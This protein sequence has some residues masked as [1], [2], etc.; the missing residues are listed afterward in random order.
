M[1]KAKGDTIP[2]GTVSLF[3]SSGVL[4]FEPFSRPAAL[5]DRCTNQGGGFMKEAELI[6]RIRDGDSGAFRELFELYQDRALRAAYLITGN[7]ATAEDVV[8]EAFV[9]CHFKLGELKEPQHFKTWF[10]RLLT[11]TAWQC[12]KADRKN[13][14]VADIFEKVE[15]GDEKS[16]E[17]QY[18]ESEMSNALYEQIRKLDRNKQTTVILFYYNGLSTRE[19][20]QVMECMEGTVKS[21]L[22]FARKALRRNLEIRQLREEGY[23]GRAEYESGL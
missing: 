21:R 3:F 8:Q 10:Y 13:V 9:K 4:F 7:Q 16:T 19:I 20:A 5:I 15:T 23:D 17:Q 1:R 11:R 22:H 18:L 12:V 6:L 14:P 2:H